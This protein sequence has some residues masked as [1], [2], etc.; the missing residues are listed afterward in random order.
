MPHFLHR[1]STL[2]TILS[3][4]DAASAKLDDFLQELYGLKTVEV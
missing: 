4:R 2:R 3:E 1:N